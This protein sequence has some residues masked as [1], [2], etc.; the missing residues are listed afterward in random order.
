M[1]QSGTSCTGNATGGISFQLS[2]T[3]GNGTPHATQTVPIITNGSASAFATNGIMLWTAGSLNAWASGD[4]TV[5]T[6]GS[7]IQYATTYTTCSG[8][9]TG[10]YAVSAVVTRLH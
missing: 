8:G 4:I 6:N 5:D 10:T 9:G 7:M 1:Y 3:D 2:W